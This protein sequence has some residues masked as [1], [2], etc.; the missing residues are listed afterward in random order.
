MATIVDGRAMPPDFIEPDHRYE[1]DED[2]GESAPEG[3]YPLIPGFRGKQFPYARSGVEAEAYRKA[4]QLYATSSHGDD[5]NMRP[6]LIAC[7]I[8]TKDIQRA[9]KHANDEDEPLK[10]SIKSGG[11]QY[12]GA[13]STEAP[14][15]MLD[16]SQTFK[17]SKDMYTYNEG[18]KAMVKVSVSQSLGAFNSF[19]VKNKM[20]VPHGRKCTNALFCGFEENHTNLE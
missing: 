3:E 2:F 6:G 13:C 7:P 10:L 15:I 20:F 16:L 8:D 12:S 1:E 17:G 9:V 4:N 18:D 14:N 19:L 11:H 5:H